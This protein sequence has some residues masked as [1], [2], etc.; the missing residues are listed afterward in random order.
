MFFRFDRTYLDSPRGQRF[1]IRYGA[2]GMGVYAF[3]LQAIDDAQD[4]NLKVEELTYIQDATKLEEDLFVEIFLELVSGSAINLDPATHSV[5]NV[6]IS[7]DKK[8]L[9]RKREAFNRNCNK[10]KPFDDLHRRIEPSKEREEECEQE[11]ELE[12]EKEGE[13]EGEIKIYG[14]YVKLTDVELQ[15]ITL[16]FSKDSLLPIDVERAIEK[17]DG[18]L[19]NDDNRKAVKARSRS[20]HYR[21]L[22]DWP[23]RETIIE[24]TERQKLQNAQKISK[25]I[26]SRSN[27]I[28]IDKPTNK[29]PPPGFDIAKSN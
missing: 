2:A 3:L 8:T 17:L 7:R 15:K 14:K 26:D 28:S 18:W 11:Q 6:E 4:G 9:K 21:T 12:K 13:C 22:L 19:S 5:S 16:R 23:L 29:L 20:S 24:A 1:C 25:S 10:S 27:G